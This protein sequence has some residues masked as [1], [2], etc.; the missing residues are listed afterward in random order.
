MRIQET[1]LG[2]STDSQGKFVIVHIPSGVY[3]IKISMIGYEPKFLNNVVINPK[4]TTWRVIELT[5]TI[6]EMEGITVTASYFQQAKDAVLSNR[7]VD[8]EEI[9]MD[10]GSAEDIQRVMQTLP[11]VVSGSDQENEIIVRGGMP[12]ENLFVMDHIEIPNPN[13]FAYQGLGGGPIN[14]INTYFVRR[15]DFYAGAFPARYGDKASSAMDIILRDGDRKHVTGHG[16]MGM[17][18]AG[19]IVEGPIAKGRGAYLLSARKSFLDLI[20][21]SIGLTAVP[22]YYSLQ[23]RLVYDLN[24]SHQ[25]IWNGIYGHD[26]ITIEGEKK[27][28]GYDRGAENVRSIG[29]QYA[30]GITL[31][32]LYGN[33]GFSRVTLSQVSNHWDQNVWNDLGKQYYQN[34]STE[35]EQT[36]RADWIYQFNKRFELSFGGHVKSIPFDLDIWVD[37][38]TLRIYQ[39]GTNIVLADSLI[40]PEFNEKN[41]QTTFKAAGFSQIKWNPFPRFTLNTGL[42]IDYFRYTRKAVFDP[43]IGFS[44]RIN[45][46]TD[47][48][49]AFGQYSQSPAYV[50]VTAHPMNRNLGYK[51]TRQVVL[52]MAKLFGEDFRG[53]FEMFY[54]EY[55]GVPISLSD[56]SVNPFDASEGRLVNCGKG[57]SKGFEFFL[58]KKLIQKYHFIVSYSYSIARGRDPRNNAFFDWDYDY[59]HNFALIGGA[60]Y[61]FQ[62]MPWFQRFRKTLFYR[63]FGWFLPFADQM[64]IGVRWRYLGGRPYTELTY[65]PRYRRW[66]VLPHTPLNAVRYPCYHRLDFR[67]DRRYMFNGW[68]MVTYFDIMNLYG[69]DNIWIYQY[70]SDGTRENIYQFQTFPVG[71][72]TI[73]F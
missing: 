45:E 28:E 71:G 23:G 73:E 35:T 41:R 20:I 56:L 39:P 21:S 15:V 5:P 49:L 62:D 24:P 48:N 12:G 30:T 29:Y 14:M 1:Q 4:K 70:N 7:S 51:R 60:R 44:Y 19:L 54:K 22:H 31:R 2:T 55:S 38:D 52:G 69:R 27:S 63:M 13:H 59:R 3:N 68:N 36:F 43:R 25:L 65:L 37:R 42:R 8:F 33:L 67:I 47:L 10:P 64:D 72:I 34:L 66:I 11:S 17:A 16:Y 6:L 26:A 40:Y 18:G 46:K 57:F 53:T 61:E 9:R 58:Q 32:T 50:Q